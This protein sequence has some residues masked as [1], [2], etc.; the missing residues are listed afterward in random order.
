MPTKAVTAILAAFAIVLGSYWYASPYLALRSMQAA[1]QA[2]DAERLNA[3]VD[4]PRLRESLKGQFS[5]RLARELGGDAGSQNALSQLGAALGTTLGAAL[6]DRLIDALVQPEM[7][8][9]ALTDAEFRPR[10]EARPP[11]STAESSPSVIWSSDRVDLNTL[12][13]HGRR[14]TDT[15][16]RQLTLVFE[17]SG[18]ADWKLVAIQLPQRN[19]E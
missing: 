15:P 8:M 11:G 7:V 3:H 17:R 5:A 13:V 1:A 19:T 4:Y 10:M 12:V 2:R 9:R 14:Q 16:D 6:G 18:F